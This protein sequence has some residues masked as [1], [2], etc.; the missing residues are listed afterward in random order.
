LRFR[1]LMRAAIMTHSFREAK[2][3]TQMGSQSTGCKADEKTKKKKTPRRI[4]EWRRG[5]VFTGAYPGSNPETR[6]RY[7]RAWGECARKH[8]HQKRRACCTG[9]EG[10]DRIFGAK[11]RKGGTRDPWRTAENGY[12]IVRSRF[13]LRKEKVTGEEKKRGRGEGSEQTKASTE[14]EPLVEERGRGTNH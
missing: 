10:L 1:E 3:Q 12:L 7:K 14:N 13:K 4:P 5:G 11:G 2:D 9:P 8:R 6:W